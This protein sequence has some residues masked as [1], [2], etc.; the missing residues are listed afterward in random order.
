MILA[1]W[2][3]V[4]GPNCRPGLGGSLRMEVGPRVE[5][6]FGGRYNMLPAK[7]HEHSAAPSL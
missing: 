1:R 7:M 5:Q 2:P 3:L 4:K 6:H